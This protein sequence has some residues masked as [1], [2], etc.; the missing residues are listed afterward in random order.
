MMCRGFPF[1]GR[2]GVMF[3]SCT[4]GKGPVVFRLERLEEGV[5]MNR[6]K[7][8]VLKCFTKEDIFRDDIPEDLVDSVTTNEALSPGQEFVMEIMAL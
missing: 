5:A 2:P 3:S 4:D 6:L 8:T 1:I 7:I